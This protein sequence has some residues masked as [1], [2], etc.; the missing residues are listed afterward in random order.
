MRFLGDV[1][2]GRATLA[3]LVQAGHDAISTRDRL[4][5]T[6]S[7]T[8]IIRLALAENRVILCFDLDFATIV[9]VSGARLPSVITFRTR[10]RN[11]EY[12]NERLSQILPQVC[13]DLVRGALVTVDDSEARV[14][15]LPILHPSSE[16]GTAS[17][18]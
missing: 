3:N 8:E 10:T 5:T 18:E 2:I 12:V 14:R 15:L 11:A 4:P 7:D 17:D 13:S 1:P 6:A 9:A 16:S